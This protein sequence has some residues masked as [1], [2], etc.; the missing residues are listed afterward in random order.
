MEE[1]L[2][3]I[4]ETITLLAMR[5]VPRT[6][7]NEGEGIQNQANGETA[8]NHNYR[9]FDIP[10]GMGYDAVDHNEAEHQYHASRPGGAFH[11]ENQMEEGHASVQKDKVRQQ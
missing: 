2:L 4:K 5:V 3:A 11:P 1:A 7:G 6:T 8:Q 10:I 9:V